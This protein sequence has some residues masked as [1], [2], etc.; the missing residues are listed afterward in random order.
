M[1]VAYWINGENPIGV[2]RRF[3]QGL[4]FTGSVGY[5]PD[6]TGRMLTANR[7][8]LFR[9][10]ARLI[11]LAD[12]LYA[13]NQEIPRN[14]QRD[15]RV[16]YRHGRSTGPE[17]NVGLA[18]GH[19]EGLA[20]ARFPRKWVSGVAGLEIEDVRLENLGSGFTVYADPAR[21]LANP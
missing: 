21:A 14:G 12:G 8:T 19:A 4:H 20:S 11:A 2:P 15:S 18:D 16:G 13:G 5:G 10:P 7:Q 9:E 6:P 3:T 17:C 1:R